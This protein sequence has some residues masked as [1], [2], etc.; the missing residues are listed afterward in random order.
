MRE[1]VQAYLDDDAREDVIIDEDDGTGKVLFWNGT[2]L[3]L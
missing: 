2:R 3:C 1:Q